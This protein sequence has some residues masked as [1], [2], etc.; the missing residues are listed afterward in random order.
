MAMVA[1]PFILATSS[2]AITNGERPKYL[3]QECPENAICS[4]EMGQK[5][6]RWL[7]FLKKIELEKTPSSKAKK[8]EQYRKREGIPL[9][10]WM[11]AKAK[12]KGK[13][14][15]RGKEV[16]VISWDSFCPRHQREGQE[17]YIGEVFAKDFKTLTPSTFLVV[18]SA[19]KLKRTGN[20]VA[21]YPIPRGETPSHISGTKLVFAQEYEGH[22]Y[23]LKTG[24]QGAT[25]VV[26]PP[27]LSSQNLKESREIDC[28]KRLSGH[29]KK[30]K[31]HP[32]YQGHFCK[33]IW[34]TELKVYETMLFPW[35][36]R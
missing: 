31:N 35:P 4:K 7:T 21:R 23:F 26:L 8:I 1:L 34:N 16:D 17:L 15:T 25:Q 29:F 11:K 13:G 10:I 14:K 27:S 5:R 18:D 24:P 12:G 33:A 22:Y 19:Y 20:G 36:C 32:L 28:P 3:N 30:S 6:K 9:G 2:S